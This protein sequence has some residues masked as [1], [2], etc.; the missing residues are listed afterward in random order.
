[1]KISKEGIAPYFM[2]ISDMRDQFQE[3]GEVMSDREMTIVVLNA[4][5]KDWAT[6]HQEYMPR[7]KLLH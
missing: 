5:P 2:N 6:S 3:L 4:L 1:M 7:R